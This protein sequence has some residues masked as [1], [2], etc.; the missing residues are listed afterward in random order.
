MGTRNQVG[1]KLENMNWTNP[2]HEFQYVRYSRVNKHKVLFSIFYY[3]LSLL[4]Y[5][6]MEIYHQ[7][8]NLHSSKEMFIFSIFETLFMIGMAM[9]FFYSWQTYSMND[10]ADEEMQFEGDQPKF[11]AIPVSFKEAFWY[12]RVSLWYYASSLFLSAPC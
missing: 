12:S 7:G 2:R 6:F 9:S 10:Y 3:F 11:E 4:A 1:S 5:Y 8:L